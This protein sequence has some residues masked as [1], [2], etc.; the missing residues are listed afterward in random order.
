[1]KLS[2]VVKSAVAALSLSL[3]MAVPAQAVDLVGSGASFPDGLIQGCKA[4]FTASGSNSYQYNV[5]SSGGGQTDAK[6]GKGNFWFSDGIFTTALGKPSTMIHLP[7]VAGPV[8]I[9]YNLPGNAGKTLSLSADTI[10]GIFAG[11]I[12]KWNDPAIVKDSNRTVNRVTYRTKNGVVVKD[13]KGQPVVLRKW[14]ET[15]RFTLPAR[16]IKVVYRAD[17][18]GTTENFVN[19]L[20]GATTAD[21]GWTKGKS[22]VTAFKGTGGNIDG[23]ANLG[24]YIGRQ[25]SAGVAVEVAKTLDSITYVETSFAKDNNLRVADV[26]NASGTLVGPNT[27]GAVGAFLGSAA[28]GAEEGTYAFDYKTKDAGAYPISIVSYMI[29]DTKYDSASTAAAVKALANFI[30]SPACADTVGGKLGFAVI[31]GKGKE[32]A[33]KQ[34]AKIGSK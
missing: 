2:R 28:A 13:A 15:I 33:D 29:A 17:D 8:A 20:K 23:S 24:R 10:A 7:I 3:V 16:N 27:A 19:Y 18:S 4:G 21:A 9:A 34:I 22:F 32:V 1:M 6:V 11:T 14:T 26:Y 25:K 30:L 5:S 12:T 31:T